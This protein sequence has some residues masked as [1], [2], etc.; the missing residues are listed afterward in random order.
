MLPLSST[1]SRPRSTSIA[2]PV[3]TS[4]L[5]LNLR[6]CCIRKGKG[7]VDK[8]PIEAVN[9]DL[10]IAN[11]LSRYDERPVFFRPAW[12]R[13]WLAHFGANCE[14]LIRTAESDGGLIGVAPLMRI[15]NNLT[16]I[17]DP[18]ITDFMDFLIDPE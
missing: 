1:P 14:P 16:F 10:E 9:L 17:G 2:R 8:A 11:L 12:L 18:E 7:K 13:T 3:L 6:I 15:G 4:L 5:A